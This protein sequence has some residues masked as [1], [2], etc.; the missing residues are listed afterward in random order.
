MTLRNAAIWVVIGVL[1][2]GL[3]GMFNHTGRGA[4]T[5]ADLTYSQLLAKVQAGQIKGAVVR[6]PTR[7]SRTLS[8]IAGCEVWLKFENRTIAMVRLRPIAPS[9]ITDPIINPSA[10]T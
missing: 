2:I 3:Y 10:T 8:G 9:A 5:A 7:H 4:G 1:L 6:T